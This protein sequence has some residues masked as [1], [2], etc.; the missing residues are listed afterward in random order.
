LGDADR[1]QLAEIAAHR[2]TPQSIVLRIK[3]VLGASQKL[4]VAE[5]GRAL[6]CRDHAQANTP[7]HFSQRPRTGEGH[8]KATS[9]RTTSTP[10]RLNG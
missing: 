2:S 9:R 3:I 4:V 7:W 1:R 6:V 8:R 5:S 10:T